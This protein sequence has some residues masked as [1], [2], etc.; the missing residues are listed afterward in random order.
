MDEYP[1]IYTPEQVRQRDQYIKE[2]PVFDLA[3]SKLK[4][5]KDNPKT[6]EKW[7]NLLYTTLRFGKQ[8]QKRLVCIMEENPVRKFERE[9]KT[10][11]QRLEEMTE[12][13][14]DPDLE[15]TR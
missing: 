13:I 6:R 10:L 8:I 14:T 12:W 2:R 11:K 7:N 5:Y 9:R 4:R 15:E 1:I 3:Y